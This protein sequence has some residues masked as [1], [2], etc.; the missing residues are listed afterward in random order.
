MR[1]HLIYLR[2][3]G[4]CLRLVLAAVSISAI[5]LRCV[6]SILPLEAQPKL[7]VQRGPLE[8]GHEIRL[9]L[10]E[11]LN[12]NGESRSWDFASSI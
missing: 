8:G 9:Q 7:I 1:S 10:Q 11:K 4:N 3:S 2:S 6:E 12:T 5:E